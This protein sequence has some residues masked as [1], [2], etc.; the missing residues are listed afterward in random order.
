MPGIIKS[1][2]MYLV[3]QKVPL[4]FSRR[5]YWKNLNELLDNPTE[6]ES[7]SGRINVIVTGYK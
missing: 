2:E 4:G 3:G 7:V 5:C 6:E 1:A